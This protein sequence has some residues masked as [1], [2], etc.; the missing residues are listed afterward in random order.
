MKVP[1]GH[2]GMKM[3][4]KDLIIHNRT[5]IQELYSNLQVLI[6]EGGSNV[7]MHCCLLLFVARLVVGDL[8]IPDALTADLQSARVTD[9]QITALWIANPQEQKDFIPC[10]G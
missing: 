9:P 7:S 5:L 10:R 6:S 4:V 1:I 8:R 2:I 3:V